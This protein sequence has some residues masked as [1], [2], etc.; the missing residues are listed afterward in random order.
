MKKSITRDDVARTAGVSAA[1]VS[2]VVNDGPRSVSAETRKKVLRAIEK[3]GYKPNAV[4]R[5]LRR[6]RTSTIGLILPDTYNP[7][8]AE[9]AR[10]VEQ[11]ALEC[12]FTVVLCHS[13]Y[14]LER[15][16]QY[17]SLLQAERA[18]GVI[19]FPATKNAEPARRLSE[20]GVPLVV[21]DR[22]VGGEK[23]SSV[24][25]DNFRGGY[26]ATQHLIDLG[27]RRIGCISRPYDLHHSQERVRGYREALED[28][29]IFI[30]NNYIV[31]GGF[32]LEEG[33]K[34]TYKLL[35]MDFAP[36]AIFAYNDIMAI[37][38]L[39]AA[40]EMNLRV[41]E[42]LSVVGF[43]DIPQSAFTCPALTTVRQPKDE[44]GK[45]GAE[46]LFEL[47]NGEISSSKI[48]PP[49]DVELV[50][51]ESTASTSHSSPREVLGKTHD[52][53]NA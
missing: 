25:A 44:M 41:P 45:R 23:S 42:D 27:H 3:L 14:E 1:T 4:A 16:L 2:Y 26:I 52:G 40:K 48:D 30:G 38:A 34:A 24:V 43:D 32:R 53:D 9:V 35:T 50:I 49:L 13:N 7:Y 28:S 10:V 12:N 5:N 36:T 20:Y 18:A 8:F 11:T 15:E 31:K 29:G 6:Q 46:I 39:R 21:L 51:R 37:G 17:V 33:R 22:N 47:I 19:W